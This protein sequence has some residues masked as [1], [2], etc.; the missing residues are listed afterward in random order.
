M[1]ILGL[2]CRVVPPGFGWLLSAQWSWQKL[3][4]L[5]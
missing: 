5:C 4:C 2:E 3:R 1:Q